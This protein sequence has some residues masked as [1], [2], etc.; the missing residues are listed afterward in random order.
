MMANLVNTVALLIV[1]AAMLIHINQHMSPDTPGCERWGFVLTAAGTFGHAFGYWF[2]TSGYLWIETIMHIGLALTAIALVRGD[3]RDM[4]AKA[5]R[6][7]GKNERR[8]NE[9]IT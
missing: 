8:T 5:R 3:L 1:C 2:Q 4:L 6:W 7:D 9:S